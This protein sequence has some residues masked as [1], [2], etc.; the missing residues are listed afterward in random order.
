MPRGGRRRRA[1]Q[2][3]GGGASGITVDAEGVVRAV[4]VK[5][6]SGKLASQRKQAQAENSQPSEESVYSPLRKISLVRLE[7]ACK[8]Y[9]DEKS[10][11]TPTM[12]FLAGLQRIEYVFV[13]PESNDL[14]IAGPAEGYVH[15]DASKRTVGVT[16]GRPPLRLDDLLVALRSVQRAGS[17]GC[18]IDP[19]EEGLA[20]F[21]QYVSDNNFPA[22]LE[23]TTA[24]YPEM[25]K[26]LG[27]QNV[28]IWG[29]PA[30]SH[31]AKTLVEADYRMKLISLG[32]ERT[33]VKSLRSHLSMIPAGG[34]ST[35]RWWFAPLYD[36]F[37]K[38][39]KTAMAFQFA[40][41]RL[42]NY[43]R[44]RN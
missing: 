36:P 21:N 3:G 44:E 7:A 26:A 30:E 43:W 40:G 24:R 14:V 28:R 5:D 22:S 9:S 29:V 38:S 12:Q 23:E 39:V 19:R 31:F 15:T 25:A 41:P 10:D 37:V 35:Q 13:L 8:K 4:F 17:L 20:R 18:S 11:V 42:R 16:T 6:K 27:M 33:A 32:L 34:N 1:E 2:G